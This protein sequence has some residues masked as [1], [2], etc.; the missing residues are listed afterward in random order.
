MGIGQAND[1]NSWSTG[2]IVMALVAVVELAAAGV[3]IVRGVALDTTAMLL[4]SAVGIGSIIV[5]GVSPVPRAAKAVLIVGICAVGMALSV[6]QDPFGLRSVER[7]VATAS[8][9]SLPAALPPEDTV[10]IAPSRRSAASGRVRITTSADSSDTGFAP[11]LSAAIVQGLP[12][13][14]P[15]DVAITG[16]AGVADGARPVY[17]VNW[18]VVSGDVNAWCGRATATAPDRAAAIHLLARRVTAAADRVARGGQ[19]CA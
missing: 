17:S 19:G 4:A 9:A 7:Q 14:G 18:S 13:R 5:L 2:A 8:R 6:A 10:A 16:V 1:D 11:D 12:D 15:R 3:L